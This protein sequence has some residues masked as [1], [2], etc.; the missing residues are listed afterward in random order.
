MNL[1]EVFHQVYNTDLFKIREEINRERL[2]KGRRRTNKTYPCP[3]EV[4]LKKINQLLNTTE[5]L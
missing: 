5:L 4:Q 3:T 1:L 2:E